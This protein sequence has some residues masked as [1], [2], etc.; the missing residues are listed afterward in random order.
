MLQ[1]QSHLYSR[2]L[3]SAF[4]AGGLP[5][6][7][8]ATCNDC[9]MCKPD[10]GFS[11]DAEDEQFRFIANGCCTYYP[12]LPNFLVGQVLA[13]VPATEMPSSESPTTS[14]DDGAEHALGVIR[15]RIRARVRCTPFGIQPTASADK[16]QT[17]PFVNVFGRDESF[18]C[19]YQRPADMICTIWGQRNSVC[20]TWF[21]KFER[22]QFSAEAWGA[23]KELLSEVETSLSSWCVRELL[24]DETIALLFDANGKPRRDV[25]R[26]LSGGLEDEGLVPDRVARRL[27]GAWHEREED[28]MRACAERVVTLVWTD[29]RRIGGERVA[30][31]ERLAGRALARLTRVDIPDRL[32]HVGLPGAMFQIRPAS[33]GQAMV[34]PGNYDVQHF[35]AEL[36]NQLP[37]FDGHSSL[38]SVRE[39]LSV[40]GIGLSDETLHRLVDYGL[41]EAADAELRQP[42]KRSS[43]QQNERL[44]MVSSIDVEAQLDFD[45]AGAAVFKINCGYKDIEFDE[46]DLLEF[47]RQ[48]VQRR[49]GFAA[50]SC[51]EWSNVPE[52]LTWERVAPLL[53]TLIAEG[54]LERIE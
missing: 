35:D 49:F 36:L 41:L 29:V 10:S 11:P 40:E 26:E 39:R 9:A 38:V 1:P 33:D 28:F 34:Y 48:L 42:G 32:R 3:D 6:E 13:R 5:E 47:G 2:W 4:G 53:D 19:P 14:H 50:G 15:S 24:D 20:S 37:A 12:E 30:V 44:R 52:P 27:W 51:T 46:R 22:G 54:V 23:V 43:V 25:A 16:I 7:S 31:L 8:R 45:Q 17:D 18:R 21:C